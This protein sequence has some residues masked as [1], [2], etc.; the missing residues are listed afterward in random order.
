[1]QWTWKKEK[2]S[3]EMILNVIIYKIN[4]FGVNLP[5]KK[6]VKTLFAFV[7]YCFFLFEIINSFQMV[8]AFEDKMLRIL[9]VFGF[10]S[11]V[12]GVAQGDYQTV[13]LLFFSLFGNLNKNRDG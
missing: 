8:E 13:I 11:L 9:T 4:R 10:I 6:K 5:P 12:I 1:M 2:M 7:R 3:L